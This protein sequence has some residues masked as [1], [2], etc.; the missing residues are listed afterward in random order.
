MFENRLATKAKRAEA[1]NDFTERG[2][3]GNQSFGFELSNRHVDGPLAGP[4][5]A[6][7]IEREIDAFPDAHAGV[8]EKKQRIT[9]QVIAPPQFLL[10]EL[11]LLRS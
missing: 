10:D 4:E 2:V 3:Y 9:G 11:V 6:Q 8:A 7:T 5:F 1:V